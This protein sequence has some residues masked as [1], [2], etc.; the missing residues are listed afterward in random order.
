MESF[1]REALECATTNISNSVRELRVQ[2]EN[3]AEYYSQ[4][5]M[6][7]EDFLMTYDRRWEFGD[8]FFAYV[9]KYLNF[10]QKI[11]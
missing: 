3:A 8:D 11:F 9:L 5:M 2:V 6:D 7:L 1:Y 4:V 10:Y